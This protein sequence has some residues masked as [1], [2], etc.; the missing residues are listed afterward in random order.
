M[1]CCSAGIAYLIEFLDQGLRR[2]DD[3]RDRLGLPCLGVIPKFRHIPGRGQAHEPN[4]RHDEAVREAYR[5][6]RI[7]LL[8]S[9]PDENLKSVVIHRCGR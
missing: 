9:T 5:R 4:H 2:A 1:A 6:L 8:F 3:V 7:N